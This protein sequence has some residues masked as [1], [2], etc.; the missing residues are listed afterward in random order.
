MDA[1]ATVVARSAGR[2]GRLR[3]LG[4]LVGLD[5]LTI[6]NLQ[7]R[8][9]G[10]MRRR[11]LDELRIQPVDLILGQESAAWYALDDDRV[12]TRTAGLI[13]LWRLVCFKIVANSSQDVIELR[14][15]ID[16]DSAV[17]YSPI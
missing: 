8:R 1:S 7:H 3:W 2:S 12:D 9:A 5:C 14:R 11:L 10:N 13:D 15:F 6:E 17:D 4:L 16:R